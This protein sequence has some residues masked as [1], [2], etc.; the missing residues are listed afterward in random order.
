VGPVLS[1]GS[2]EVEIGQ[3]KGEV[4]KE[5]WQWKDSQ[6]DPMLLALKLEEGRHEPCS[7]AGGREA[8]TMQSTSSTWQ[9]KE[10]D[11]SPTSSSKE[12]SPAVTFILAQWDLYQPPEIQGCN[13]FN[14]K[15]ALICYVVIGI[16]TPSFPLC[17][18][19]VRTS[20]CQSLY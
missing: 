11:F 14:T 13:G 16:W 4:R 18:Q 1:E 20:L 17:F 12:C 3:Q 7:E 5:M 19:T 8:W 9:D 15:F 2:L 10:I 6:R